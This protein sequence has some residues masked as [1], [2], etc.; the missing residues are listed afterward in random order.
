MPDGFEL[1]KHGLFRARIEILQ[2]LIFISGADHPPEFEPF[3]QSMEVR[4]RTHALSG[5]KIA[6]TQEYEI[7][8]NWKLVVE[9]SRECYHCGVA[10]PQYCKAVSFAAAVGSQTAQAESA[11]AE[12]AAR[13]RLQS[14]GLPV[15]E[16]PF[17]PDS[18]YHYRRFFLRP[19]HLTESMDGKP[20]AP[21]MGS[22]P[23]RD[24]G[25]FA[26]VTLPNLLLEAN[27]DYVMTLRLTPVAPQRTR[28]QVSWLVRGD[29]QAGIDYDLDRLTEFWRL[30][31]EQDWTLCENNQRGVNSSKYIPGP[32]APTEAG[33]E[34]FVQWYI[35]QVQ[36]R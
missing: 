18:W 36:V 16:V 15:E 14:L 25:V 4:L 27:G 24:T 30:T 20:V 34:H 11:S 21:L 8:A 33:V 29:A 12:T 5:A 32:Y 3:R 9:N 19:D 26:I 23:D 31:S 22:L 13:E 17:L 6:H 10:H 2:G 35:K 1:G 28:A 7:A